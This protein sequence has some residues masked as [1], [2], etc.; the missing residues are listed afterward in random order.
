[1]T[2]S[3]IITRISLLAASLAVLVNVVTGFI[4]EMR[5]KPKMRK[6]KGSSYSY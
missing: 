5:Q 2:A 4:K 3:E 6:E 1:M